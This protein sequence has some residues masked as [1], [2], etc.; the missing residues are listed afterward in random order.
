LSGV[1]KA[2]FFADFILPILR[3]PTHC[4]F[5]IVVFFPRYE[6]AIISDSVTDY[7]LVNF[8]TTDFIALAEKSKFRQD[9]FALGCGEYSVI[10]L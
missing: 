2:L 8:D 3:H 9:Y 6:F 10:V 5:A 1:H 7:C 4:V